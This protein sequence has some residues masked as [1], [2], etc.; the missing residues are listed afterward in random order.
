MSGSIHLIYMLTHVLYLS[1]VLKAQ[2]RN[3]H[4]QAVHL[5]DI[6]LRK[7]NFHRVEENLGEVESESFDIIGSILITKY[8]LIVMELLLLIDF[9][10]IVKRN[11]FVLI[12]E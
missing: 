9:D 4:K 5:T 8:G 10:S 12:L 7:Q 6:I 3:F 2:D 11:L 1:A